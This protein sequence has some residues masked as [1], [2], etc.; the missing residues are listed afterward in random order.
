MVVSGGV[1]FVRKNL[2]KLKRGSSV[3]VDKCIVVCCG[4][5]AVVVVF[6]RVA[7]GLVEVI[8]RVDG[9]CVTGLVS[10]CGCVTGF[11]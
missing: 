7:G 4:L 9:V 11:G 2:S 6:I 10:F 1:L 3:V 8:R 5:A